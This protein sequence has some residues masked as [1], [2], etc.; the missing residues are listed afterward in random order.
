MV[1]TDDSEQSHMCETQ[2]VS[3]KLK[4]EQVNR[5]WQSRNDEIH[6]TLIFYQSYLVGLVT[7]CNYISTKFTP[8]VDILTSFPHSPS[9]NPAPVPSA[10]TS[11]PSEYV[12]TY[13]KQNSNHK[14][15]IS[16]SKWKL[17]RN[18]NCFRVFGGRFKVDEDSDSDYTHE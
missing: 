9:T 3:C 7:V 12:F 11:P 13:H 2:C 17:W 4:M 18:W 14:K 5:L 16:F 15:K 8:C 6:A 10:R 1:T